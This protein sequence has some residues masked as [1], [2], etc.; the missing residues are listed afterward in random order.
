MKATELL[1]IIYKNNELYW[2]LWSYAE[3]CHRQFRIGKDL[4][5]GEYQSLVFSYEFNKR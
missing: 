5:L 3:Y 2:R 1:E 4:T